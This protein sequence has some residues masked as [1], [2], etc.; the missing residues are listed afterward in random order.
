MPAQQYI[1]GPINILHQ[2]QYIICERM[3]VINDNISY[4]L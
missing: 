1:A 3:R 2:Y 4:M